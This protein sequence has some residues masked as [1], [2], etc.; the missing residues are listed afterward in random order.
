MEELIPLIERL[1]EE[2]LKERESKELYKTAEGLIHTFMTRMDCFAIQSD[3]GTYYS[4]KESLTA[5]HVM[6]HL[7]GEI[8]LGVYILGMDGKAS[9]A[10]IDAD[11][12]E[13]FERLV[14]VHGTL[15]VPS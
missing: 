15:P 14:T 13:G 8:T 4:V 6:R 12:E 2:Y 3:T 7:K 9:F 1:K 11:D 5:G 10:V